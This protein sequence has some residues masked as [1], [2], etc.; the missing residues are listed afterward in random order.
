MTIVTEIIEEA[1]RESGLTNELQSATPTQTKQALGRLQTLI[2]TVYG[3]EVGDQL[4]DWPVGIEGVDSITELAWGA[5]QWTNPRENVRLIAGSNAAQTI[6]LPSNPD[7]G[8]RIALIDPS[9]RLEAAP[10]TLNG[11]GRTIEGTPDLIVN[12][13]GTRKTWFYRADLGNWTSISPLTYTDE[14]PFPPEFDTYFITMLATRISPTYGVGLSPQTVSALE[15]NRTRLRA[16]YT[17]NQFVPSELGILRM[18]RMASD[19]DQYDFY[20]LFD[21]NSTFNKGRPW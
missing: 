4:I 1:F 16:R 7:D 10:I 2:S 13:N 20:N 8:A 18:S 9:S 5:E 14:F 11:N 3:F 21:P 15:R 19:R 6:F 12:I 17:Q